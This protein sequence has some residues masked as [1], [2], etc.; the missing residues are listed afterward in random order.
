[1]AINPVKTLEY[2]A[3]GCVVVSTAIPD[4]ARFYSD[5]V[6]IASGPEDFVDKVARVMHDDNRER[7]RKGI[8]TARLR[9][10]ENMVE[11]MERSI[12]SFE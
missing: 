11:E 6:L 9:S 12:S 8:E 2:L 4:V 7:I 3:A 1:M 10:W 5:V